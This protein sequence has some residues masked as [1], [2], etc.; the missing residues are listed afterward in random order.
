[1][2]CSVLRVFLG[3]VLFFLASFALVIHLDILPEH[4]GSE[5]LF[6]NGDDDNLPIAARSLTPVLLPPEEPTDYPIIVWWTPFTPTQRRINKCPKGT[7]LVTHSRTELTNPKTT[8]S[9]FIY[10]GTEFNLNDVP[11][12]RKPNHLWALLHEE[13]PKNN[14]VLATKKGI[15]LFNITSTVSRYSD[16]PL[17]LHYLHTLEH[18]LQPVRTPAHL[19]SKKDL[20]LVIFLQSGCNPPSDRDAYVKELMKFIS[21]DSYGKCLHNKDLPEHLHNP[22]TFGTDDVLDIVGK[23]KFALSFENALCQDYFTEKFWRPLYAG[24]VPI[25]RGSPTIR[26]W[27]PSSSHPSIILADDFD[28]PR[29]L[30]EYLLKLDKNDTEY[31]RYLEFKK[32]GVT[33]KLLL[34]H[35]NTRKWVVDAPGE[36]FIDGFEC[37]VCDTLHDRKLRKMQE[38]AK[39]KKN[40]NHSIIAN[41]SHYDCP[42]PKPSVKQKSQRDSMEERE[43]NVMD[44]ENW[45][46]VAQRAKE[47]AQVASDAIS[48]GADQKQLDDALLKHMHDIK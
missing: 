27:D 15:A 14:W 45:I 33:N 8:V 34:E 21:V 26:D 48:R 39:G 36:N 29:E 24:S 7:C 37:F 35:Y 5:E 40:V 46:W 47:K 32:I 6:H 25:V 42:I 20:G 17:H 41:I 12:P 28:S 43:S 19:K 2:R 3:S 38:E 16:Y 11:L 30:A 13:S 4:E 18:L 31:E 23:Y 10:Y 44:L 1:M 22:L 9:A